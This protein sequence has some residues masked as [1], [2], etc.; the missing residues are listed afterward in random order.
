[1]L[2]LLRPSGLADGPININILIEFIRQM[3]RKTTMNMCFSDTIDQVRSGA[4]TVTIRPGWD[5]LS[6]GDLI[7]ATENSIFPEF[8][9]GE[10]IQNIRSIKITAVRA[11]NLTDI[12]E[13]DVIKCGFNEMSLKQFIGEICSKYNIPPWG[14]AKRIEFEYLST[15]PL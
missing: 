12:M 5:S 8:R 14:G 2:V 13:R 4:Q 1:M 7:M 10:K 3:R 11:I 15:D 9:K 6:P